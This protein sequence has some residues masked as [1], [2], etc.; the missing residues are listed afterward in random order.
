MSQSPNN[1]KYL[2]ALSYPSEHS[3]YATNLDR[4][5]CRRI[6]GKTKVYNYRRDKDGLTTGFSREHLSRLFASSC[7]DV[8]LFSKEWQKSTAC[9][10]ERNRIIAKTDGGLNS[11]C[12]FLIRM[13]DAELQDWQDRARHRFSKEPLSEIVAAIIRKLD[14]KLG[15]RYASERRPKALVD[16]WNDAARTKWSKIE[17]PELLSSQI[18]LAAS[19]G[20][21]EYIEHMS[22]VS[23]A[24]DFFAREC[25]EAANR[26]GSEP[27][28][29]ELL[30]ARNELLNCVLSP[31]PEDFQEVANDVPA[32]I[33][34]I[35]HYLLAHL[36]EKDHIAGFCKELPLLARE[37]LPPDRLHLLSGRA[38]TFAMQLR[39]CHK[40]VTIP[41]N[42]Y[43]LNKVQNSAPL[44][45]ALKSYTREAEKHLAKHIL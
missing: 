23:G 36:S 8:I 39:D 26:N 18:A 31:C 28:S 20:I 6:G 19:V 43:R 10:W 37:A 13:D 9:E 40:R 22:R 5:L 16:N 29:Y 11:G 38:A 44:K 35:Q 1:F 32:K 42:G 27:S 17:D 4:M 3:D 33:C 24:L 34:A 7:L 15:R 2:I 30:K 14:N 25:R 21:V 41:E 45:D 12:V